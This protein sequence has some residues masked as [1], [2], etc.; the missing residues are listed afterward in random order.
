MQNLPE[1]AW[2]IFQACI[3]RYHETDSVDAREDNPYP[4]G[5]LEYLLYHKNWIDNV[6]WHLEDIIRDEDILPEDALAIKR[7]IDA[8]NQQRTDTV[9][10][11]DDEFLSY[12]S[13][14]QSLSD[15]RLN[16]ETPA[17]AID[18]LSILSL[19]VYHMEIEAEREKNG[20][21]EGMLC[22][23]KLTVLLEQKIDLLSSVSQLFSDIAQG[24]VRMKTYKQMKMYND[25][26]L[27]PVLYSKLKS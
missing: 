25:A 19:K 8:L 6:Q 16:T 12:F 3:S 9:E 17:W 27:N 20:E 22:Q 5:S 1:K 23:H 21:K 4:V 13:H 10:K 7:R 18:R 2:E 14:V 15:A 26:E 11:L 24:K